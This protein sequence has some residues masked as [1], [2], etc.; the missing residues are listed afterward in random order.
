[1][2]LENEQET[3]NVTFSKHGRDNSSDDINS[4]KVTENR[5]EGAIF[6]LQI[7]GPGGIYEDMPGKTLASAFNGYFGFRNLKPGRY[8]LMEVKAPQGYKPIKD[9]VLHFTIAYEKGEIDKETGEITPGRGVVTLEYNEGNGIFQ[10]APDKKGPDGNPITPEDGKLTDYVTSA[11]A[12]NMGKI[13]NEKPGKGKVTLTKYDDGGHLLPGAEF[14]LT[15]LTRKVTGTDDPNKNDSVKTK[16][17]DEDGKIVFDELPIGQYELEETKPAPGYQN[18]GKKWRFT[19]GGPG[20]DPYANDSEV[21][22]RDISSKID[23]TSTMSV[24]RP[25]SIDGT[26]SEGNSKIHPHKG[27]A[28]EFKN[29]FKINDDTVI[30]PGDY[31]TIKLTDNINLD[32]ILKQ[33]SYGL[34]L[35]ADGVGTI[36]KAKYDKEAGTLT[37][38]FT[39]YAE[40]YNKTD[41]ENTISAHINLMKVQ[42]STQNVPVGMGIGTPTTNN[43]DVVYDLDTARA[44]GINM[45]SKIVSFDQET[46]EFVQYYYLNRDRTAFNGNQTFKYKPREAV[47]NL[48]FDLFSLNQNGGSLYNYNTGQYYRSDNYVNKDM[49][50]SFG[51][52]EYSNNLRHD[53][54]YGYYNIGANGIQEIPIGY[55]GIQDSVIVKVTGKVKGDNIASYDTYA[56]LYDSISSYYVERTN[57]IRIFENK[58]QAS[59]ELN[60]KAVNP[61]NE[62]IFKKVDKEGKILPGAEFKLVRYYENPQDGKNWVEFT[63]SERTAGEDGL[64]KYEKL[65]AGRYALI[66]TKAPTGYAKIEGHIQEFT[67]GTDGVITRQVVKPAEE[68]SEEAQ[69]LRAKVAK[70]VE[71]LADKL[72]GNTNTETYTEKLSAEPIEVV[73]YKNIEFEKVDANDKTKK[74]ANAEFEVYYKEKEDGEYQAYKVTKDGKEVTKTVTSDKDGKISLNVTKPGYYALKETKAP[75]GYTK[76]PDYIKEFRVENGKLQILEKDPLKASLTRGK[77]GQI[78]S[79]VL[80]VDK[81]NKTFTQ[82]IVIN[83][84]HDSLT[85]INNS[86][87]LRILENYWSI[88]PKATKGLGGEVKV[89]LLKKDPGEKDKKSIEELTEKDFKNLG[90]ISYDTVGNNRGSRYSLKELLGKETDSS[91][92][93]TTDTIV[94]EYT[95]KI[96]D[97]FMGEQTKYPIKQKAELVIDDT[98]LDTADYGLDIDTLSINKPTYGD[99]TSTAPIQ[100]ENRKATF[101]LTGALGIFGFL[102][103]GAIIMTTSYYKYRKKKRGRALS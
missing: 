94:V 74:L 48:K 52:N 13:I 61:K 86:S 23:M 34:D 69:T 43:I 85:G 5:L 1:M 79:Q 31:F 68:K 92:I 64:I 6:K 10:Y 95:G 96:E 29:T 63:G 55:L 50:E 18:K 80:S 17:V 3:Y 98:V 2:E 89:A 82:R 57:G 47:T 24:Q 33:K 65:E 26:E 93:S 73:N 75:D 76:M 78:A 84:N 101:P 11:T 58:T 7:Q 39:S 15:R 51:V 99:Y 22:L 9:P 60:I 37:Y 53:K 87:Y 90:A 54:S 14:R 62:I 21:G 35:F 70:A 49:P 45:T 36:A 20:L 56:M 83:P 41:F 102:I 19:V 100:I 77:K 27:H 91:V 32:G 66:E 88:T 12:K 46:G 38:V 8:R 97:T 72:T 16:V 30:K 81:D 71:A 67:V 42:N 4:E 40:Q 25:D 59:A 103:A 28:L 44:A